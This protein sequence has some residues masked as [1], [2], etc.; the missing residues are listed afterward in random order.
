MVSAV[1]LPVL[2][3][4]RRTKNAQKST[5]TGYIGQK[6]EHYTAPDKDGTLTITL[7]KAPANGTLINF[8]SAWPHLRQN[9]ENNGV[10]DYRTPVYAK[11]AE[12]YWA[13]S[14]GSGYDVN[15]C[16]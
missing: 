14:I 10:V 4:G 5:C 13:T 2:R 1:E 11:D 3:I 6:V 15:A 12:L 8:D 7:E 9:N 16:G